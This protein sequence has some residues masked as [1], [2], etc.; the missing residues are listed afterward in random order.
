MTLTRLY[1]ILALLA[2]CILAAGPIA[3]QQGMRH[4][5]GGRQF[6]MPERD[7]FPDGNFTFCRIRYTSWGGWQKWSIDY[8]DS[9]VNFSQRLSELTSLKVNRDAHGGV[10]HVVIDLM[11]DAL[12]NYPF[13]YMIEV[14]ELVLSL[15]ERARL[16]DYL[17]RG[18]FLMV[19]DF[20]GEDEWRNWRQEIEQVFPPDEYPMVELDIDH[21][22]FN[23]VFP[24]KE[25]P[26]IPAIG[27]WV[28][29]GIT[30]ERPDAKTPHYKGI[31]D[32][33][34]RLMAIIC[35]NTDL[36]DGWEREAESQSYFEEFSA[37]KAYP[38]GINI[39]VYAMT[40]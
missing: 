8:P 6:E 11:D 10:Q 20:W 40:H 33:N 25:K 14:G 36:G 38:L 17:L 18:G 21:P 15:E 13:I 9:D 5:Q 30:Y 22:V 27:N 39:V 34:G 4:W 16:R 23:I 3:A 1:L 35:H 37:K 12:F 7:I 19:D 28:N 31:S 26:Q 29:W 2:M 24:L 32:K